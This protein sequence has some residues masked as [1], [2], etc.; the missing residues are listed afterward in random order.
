MKPSREIAEYAALRRKI[1][2]EYAALRKKISYEYAA[3]RA[4]TPTVKLVYI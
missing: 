3:L 1:S 2:Y 4:Y